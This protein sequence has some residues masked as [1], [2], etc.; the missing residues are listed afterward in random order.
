MDAKF[1]PRPI[2]TMRSAASLIAFAGLAYLGLCAF[3]YATQRSQIYFPT[4]ESAHQHARALRLESQGER[5]K[6]WQVLRPG[7]GA[8]IYFGG[9]AEDTAANIPA[10]SVALPHHSLYFANYRGYGGS[11]GRPSERALLA[12][13]LALHDHVRALHDEVDVMGRSLGSGVAVHVAAERPVRAV[14]LVSPYDSLVD[15]AR[16]HF[17][18]LPVRLLMRDRYD[19]AGRAARVAAPVLVVIAGDDEIIPRARS[20]ALVSVFRPGQVQVQVAPQAGH[21]T[22]DGSPQYLE[23]VAAFLRERADE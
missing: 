11:T 13:A 4:P 12:D 9:N 19:S 8:L 7:P 10:F 1:E 21:N 23:S 15:V 18:W 16:A 17:P 14:V 2:R 20:D 6:V 3:M 5:L 22:L